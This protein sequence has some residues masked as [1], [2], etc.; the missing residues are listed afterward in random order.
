MH[1]SS[2]VTGRPAGLRAMTT[3]GVS[4]CTRMSELN[5]SDPT[6]TFSSQVCIACGTGPT[7]S[8]GKNA[9]SGADIATV[10][11]VCTTSSDCPAISSYSGDISRMNSSICPCCAFSNG[12]GASVSPPPFCWSNTPV[13]LVLPDPAMWN[14][15]CTEFF[16]ASALLRS[17]LPIA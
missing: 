3:S 6:T 9:V 16:S 7:W 8:R 2:D 5:D 11:S 10:S 13:S 17:A 15:H 12:A 14:A 1:R 4:M